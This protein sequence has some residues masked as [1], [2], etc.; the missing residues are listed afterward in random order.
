M[1]YPFLRGLQFELIALRELSQM[2]SIHRHVCPIIE[3]VRKSLTSLSTAIDTIAATGWHPY[4]ILNPSVGELSEDN[5][6]LINLYREEVCRRT[7]RPALIY[8]DNSEHIRSCIEDLNLE[9]VMIICM[10][11]ITDTSGLIDVAE[12]TQVEG[13]VLLDPKKHRRLDSSLMSLGKNY[14]RLDDCF[15]PEKRNADY[16][17]IPAQRFTEEHLYYGEDGYQG[18]SDF[19][20]LPMTFDTGGW[21]P[22]AVAIHWSYISV[23]HH[24]EIWVRHFTSETN[25]TQSNIQGKFAEAVS[26]LYDAS[27]TTDEPLD[28]N[29]ALNEMLQYKIDERYPGLGVLKK[30]SI[31]NHILV[32]YQYLSSQGENGIPSR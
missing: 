20:L 6:P 19:T 26:K 11:D 14:I 13:L 25:Q 29:E 1:Y 32:N 12:H 28:R 4:L 7:L 15:T 16:L 8:C 5:T 30:L 2:T 23:T 22:M 24:N 17:D 21:L 31:K 18:Y 9:N 10:S 27:Q 3:P